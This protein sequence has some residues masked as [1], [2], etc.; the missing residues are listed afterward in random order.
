MKNFMIFLTT[1][2]VDCERHSLLHMVVSKGSNEG[3]NAFTEGNASVPDK[4]STKLGAGQNEIFH[5]QQELCGDQIF[6]E[7]NINTQQK[8]AK[9]RDG[10]S[11]HHSAWYSK[12]AGG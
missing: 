12:N 1:D 2:R 10:L 11:R 7:E 8:R 4:A 6:F 9:S 3:F 5:R